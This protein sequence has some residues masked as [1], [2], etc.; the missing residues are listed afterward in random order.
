MAEF[1]SQPGQLVQRAERTRPACSLAR[2]TACLRPQR[3]GLRV[4]RS[5][6]PSEET[7]CELGLA[8]RIPR[9]PLQVAA[10]GR[11]QD[12]RV[13]PGDG[14]LQSACLALQHAI[15]WAQV[16]VE[17]EGAASASVCMGIV[18]RS[19]LQLR[20]NASGGRESQLAL[21]KYSS[22][23]ILLPLLGDEI[24]FGGFCLTRRPNAR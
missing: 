19:R 20:S 5:F 4:G 12:G 24:C 3:A 9:R 7:Q 18:A 15:C 1:G 2:S 6:E 8:A 10:D 22:A 14:R 13:A 16:V 21:G 23:A 17:L 11:R